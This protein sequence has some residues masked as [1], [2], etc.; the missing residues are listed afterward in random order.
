MVGACRSDPLI[1]SIKYIR[2]NHARRR[3]HL[4]YR[5]PEGDK[6]MRDFVL[7][8]AEI[9][10]R[11]SAFPQLRRLL[12]NWR[13][14]RRLHR[15]ADLDDHMLRDIGLSRADIRGVLSQPLDVDPIW[16][17]ERLASSHRLRAS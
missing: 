17:L 4:R 10:D 8:Q 6:T 9:R 5:N 16:E 1:D 15:L 7:A 2:L 11:S 3:P 13:K 12:S 14:R